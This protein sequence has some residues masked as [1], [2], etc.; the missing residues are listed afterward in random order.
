MR[1]VF[2]IMGAALVCTT[3]TL[4]VYYGH[5]MQS[6]ADQPEGKIALVRI[7][8]ITLR[9]EVADTEA[10]RE[11]GLSGTNTLADGTAMLFVFQ[12]DGAWGF[13]MKDMKY[14]LDIVWVNRNDEV[15]T[16]AR[17]VDPSTYPEAFYPSAPAR[18]ALE[19]PAG[20]AAA[21]SLADG[22]KIVLQ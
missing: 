20:W 18:Y 17:D 6:S 11:Q 1:I 15:V 5:A 22:S 10:L 14:P 7:A 19:L 3:V 16:I 13:W 2:L 21:H 4:L 12:T 8:G 9:A